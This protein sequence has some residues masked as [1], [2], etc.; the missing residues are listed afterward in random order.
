MKSEGVVCFPQT[1]PLI[2]EP[3]ILMEI[4]TGYGEDNELFSVSCLSDIELKTTKFFR[5]YNL[6]EELLKSVQTK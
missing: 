3:R 6:Q 4:N 2:D 1:R 5:L